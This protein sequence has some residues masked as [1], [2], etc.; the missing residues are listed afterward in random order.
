M[1]MGLRKRGLALVI[2][3]L[4]SCSSIEEQGECLEWFTTVIETKERLPFPLIGEVV[5][6]ETIIFCRS[7]E[8][9]SQVTQRS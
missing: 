3:L 4:T 6:E 7:K 5:R 8:N 2:L 9:E 1:C